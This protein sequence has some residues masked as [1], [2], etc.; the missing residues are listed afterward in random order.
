MRVC[1]AGLLVG[2]VGLFLSTR[3]AELQETYRGRVR[4]YGPACRLARSVNRVYPQSVFDL[5]RCASRYIYLLA[6][7]N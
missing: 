2:S 1:R 7:S 6:T 3:V 4:T 5:E